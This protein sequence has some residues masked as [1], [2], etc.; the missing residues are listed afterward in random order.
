MVAMDAQPR[1]GWATV[2]SAAAHVL[3]LAMA[4]RFPGTPAPLLVQHVELIPVA[5]IG[6]PG[7]SPANGGASAPVPEAAPPPPVAANPPPVARPPIVAKRPAP[8]IPPTPSPKQVVTRPKPIPKPRPTAPEV[9]ESPKAPSTATAPTATAAAGDSDGQSAS[10]GR[11]TGDRG[12]GTGVGHPGSGGRGTGRG[13]GEG[14]GDARVAYAA[15]PR[16]EYPLIARRMGM[17]GVVL[18]SVLVR[19]DGDVGDIDL[20]QSS[21][22][23]ALDDAALR[24][25]RSRWRFVP[26]RKDGEPVDARV[27]VPIRFRL[28][29]EG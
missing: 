9:A 26:A 25:V 5:L 27:T 6:T 13:G 8:P 4:A 29:D 17:E 23:P 28:S 11:G 1:L 7:G 21:G 16:P 2:V 19:R 22:F 20:Q 10:S 24:T 12:E 3:L 15:N 18:L 14:R